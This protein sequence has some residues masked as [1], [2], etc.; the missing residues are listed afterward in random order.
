[1]DIKIV[2]NFPAEFGKIRC[3]AMRERVRHHGDF[4]HIIGEFSTFSVKAA[5]IDG[6]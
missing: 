2:N 6:G 3:P 4:P 5:G 1:V